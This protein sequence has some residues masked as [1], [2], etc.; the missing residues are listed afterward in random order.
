MR[1]GLCSTFHSSIRYP[2][3][4]LSSPLELPPCLLYSQLLRSFHLSGDF[5]SLLFGSCAPCSLCL[6]PLSCLSEPESVLLTSGPGNSGHV[7][8]PFPFMPTLAG[9]ILWCLVLK[10]LGYGICET[11]AKDRRLFR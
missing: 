5:T 2:I 8:D 11:A 3:W 10:V 1:L 7:P 6:L 4:I 9:R